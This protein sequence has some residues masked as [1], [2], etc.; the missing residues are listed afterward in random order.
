MQRRF[1][2]WPLLAGLIFAL[3][4]LSTASGQ[5]ELA[6]NAEAQCVF[7]G[8]ARKVSV[9]WHNPGPAAVNAEV[10]AQILQISRGT[11]ALLGGEILWK[12]IDVLPGQTVLES[13]QLDFPAVKAKTRFIV[14]WRTG[15]NSV[16]GTTEMLVCPTNLLA[17]LKS[18]LDSGTLGVLDPNNQLKPALKQNGV[19]FADLSE[20]PLE[21]FSGR[22]AI[23]GPFASRAQRPNSM[24]K[25]CKAMSKKGTAVLWIE[26]P[27]GPAEPPTP[28]FYSVSART[29]A[30][31]VAQ[32]SFLPNLS[33]NPQSQLKLL[34]LC[35]LALEPKPAALPETDTQP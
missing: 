10:R 26:P 1:G 17:E 24:T 28:S 31:V 14:Q 25:D 30:I 11:A 34:Q 5:I 21:E 2:A 16:L 27:P 13:A 12:K 15:T 3:A 20:S 22:L 23:L 9:V 32:S 29:N 8:G 4:G 18:I 6:T 19:Q 7:G 33:D 35:L